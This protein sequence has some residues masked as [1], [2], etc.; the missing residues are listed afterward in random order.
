MSRYILYTYQFSP[1]SKPSNSLSLIRDKEPL[2]SL[3]ELMQKKQCIFEDLL[4]ESMKF[5][6][7]NNSIDYNCKFLYKQDHI[8]VFRLANN[9]R[10]RTEENFHVSKHIHHP[11]CLIIIDNRHDIQHIA[12]EQDIN[13]FENVQIVANILTTTFNRYLK[14]HHLRIEIKKD[15]QE[16]EFW[17]LI[18]KYPKGIQM[19][20]F[21]FSYPNLPR[22]TECIDEMIKE[23]S[24]VTNSQETTFEFKSASDD[25]L[26]ISKENLKIVNLVNA[27]ANSGNKITLK[28]KGY[29]RQ[30]NTGGTFKSFE[31]DDFEL[32]LQSDLLESATDK[33]VQILNSFK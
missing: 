6:N 13:A 17:E 7:K 25:L 27:S 12:I 26:T 11:S 18:K 8:I 4:C 32:N 30:I 20:R 3:A 21:K 28:A 19:V 33:L 5:K 31:L 14:S 22:V 29:K 16:S 1:I 15:Y 2:I 10:Q 9:K 23:A 24:K